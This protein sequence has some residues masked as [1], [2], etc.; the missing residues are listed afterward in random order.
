MPIRLDARLAAV[1][2]LASGSATVCDVGCDHGKLAC[3]LVE[4]G[5]A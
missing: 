5:R 4:T 1:A 3:W 2:E